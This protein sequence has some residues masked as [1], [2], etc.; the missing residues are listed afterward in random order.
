M[1]MKKF[2]K[3]NCRLKQGMRIAS[4]FSGCGGSDL[5]VQGS[6]IFL[7]K[8]YERLPTE[9]VFAN[10][11]DLASTETY[12]ANFGDHVVHK[13]IVDIPSCDIPDHDILIGGFPCQTFSIVGQ[14]DGLNDHRGLL[15]EEMARILKE[16]SPKA[17]IA[18]NVK[19]LVNIKKGEILKLIINEFS[20]SGYNV[21]YKVLN[22]AD[23]GVPQK[24]ERIFIVG[25]RKDY[26]TKF[27][28]PSPPVKQWL[29]LKSIL[30]QK[31][32]IDKKYYFSQRAVEGLKKAN[33]A[34][35]KGRAQNI[36]EPCNTISAHLAK[37]SLNGTD[38]VLLVGRD[39]YR[40][41]TPIEA[42][43][44]QS[45]PDNFKFIGSD[46]K[47]YKQIG[48]AIPPVMMW[49]IAK[50]LIDTINVDIINIQEPL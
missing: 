7:N 10:D 12:R 28:F 43:R 48:N 46:L 38:P 42:A 15:F 9:I 23:F 3:E 18:E 33:K 20:K 27:N 40:R 45:F 21:S 44:I 41:F 26:N 30:L 6:F 49:H 50:S 17:F 39:K 34:F 32:E 25:I 16:K 37:V 11:N 1:G 13:S 31:D 36:N 35:N 4:L 8:K 47:A 14:R 22:S 2:K 19:G 5:G 29:P 24:R